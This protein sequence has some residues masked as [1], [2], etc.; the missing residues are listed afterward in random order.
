MH[1][2]I[3]FGWIVSKQIAAIQKDIGIIKVDL[4]KNQE[5]LT[6]LNEKSRPQNTLNTSEDFID[7]SNLKIPVMTI[8]ELNALEANSELKRILVSLIMY[9]CLLIMYIYYV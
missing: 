3:L 4:I 1:Y 5:L 2:Y 6:N 7:R 9:Y 8:D